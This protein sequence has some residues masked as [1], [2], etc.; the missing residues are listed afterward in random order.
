METKVRGWTLGEIATMVG[1]RLAGPA[2]LRIHRAVPAGNDDPQGITFAENEKYLTE[3]LASS[4]GAVIVPSNVGDV[5]KP[6]ILVDSPRVAFGVLLAH[7]ARPLPLAPGVHPTAVVSP[8]AI[9]DPSASIGA[10][11]VVEGGAR[12]GAGCRV[13]SFAYVGEGC[14]LGESCTVYP[15]AVLY[16]GVV[17]GARCTV[18]SGA[19]IGA[20]GFGYVWDGSK[21]HKVPQVGGVVIGE[22]VEIGANTCIDRATCG[23]T[24]V[25]DGTKIDNLVQLAHNTSVGDHTVIAGLTGVAGSTKIGDNVTIAGHV[26]LGDHLEIGDGVVLG[27]RSAAFQDVTEPGQY[28]GFPPYPVATAMRIMALQARLPELFRRIKQL[29]GELEALKR[30]A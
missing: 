21:Q 4:V 30:N 23:E 3:C 9:V 13:F 26:S 2:D 17:L 7:M 19:V 10:Y 15:H 8:N 18:H 22:D 27:G 20:D 1:G 24:V 6:A 29:E 28:F 25:G 14:E 16:Q 12:V 5:T 11:A